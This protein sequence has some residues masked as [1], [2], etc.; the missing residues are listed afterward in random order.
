MESDSNNDIWIADLIEGGATGA[1]GVVYHNFASMSVK[2]EILFDH[3]TNTDDIYNLAESYYLALPR[4]SWQSVIIGDPKTSII[5]D[6][7]LSYGNPEL[8][9]Q[10]KIFPN[11]SHGLFVVESN[12]LEVQQIN[13]LNQLGQLVFNISPAIGSRSTPIDLNA[14]ATGIYYVVLV[15]EEG[16][17]VEKI[18][19]E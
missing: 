9:K 3:Y 14:H 7:T 1:H 19:V 2:N 13:V 10:V 8:T 16:S 12:D 5:I 6:N 18:M 11:P 15:T 17:V 4:L